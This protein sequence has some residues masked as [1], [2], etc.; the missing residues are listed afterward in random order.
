MHSLCSATLQLHDITYSLMREF[1]LYFKK[2]LQKALLEM[3]KTLYLKRGKI[4]DQRYSVRL[5]G[6]PQVENK[7]GRL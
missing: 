1:E 4:E 2:Y 3:T 6:L 5:L 7:L